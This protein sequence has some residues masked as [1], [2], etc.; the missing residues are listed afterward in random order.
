MYMSII[1]FL[2][3]KVKF[4]P[5]YEVSKDVKGQLEF[6]KELDEVK[7]KQAEEHEKPQVKKVFIV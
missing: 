5:C 3:L 2:L 6:L 7:E 4:D 1:L